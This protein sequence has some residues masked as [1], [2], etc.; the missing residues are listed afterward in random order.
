MKKI[1]IPGGSGFLG[2]KLAEYFKNKGF[3][4]VILSRSKRSSEGNIQFQEW[5][6]KNQGN[7]SSS[8]E[9]AEAV[10]NLAGRSVDCRYNQRNKDLILHSRLDATK[11]VGEAIRQC[12][13][14][15]K[16]WINAGSATIYKHSLEN[17]NDEQKGIVGSGFSVEVCKAWEKTFHNEVTPNT[18]KLFLRISIVLGKNGGAFIP[19]KQ[20]VKLGLGG[21]Q[22]SGQQ[23]ISW[24]HVEDFARSIEWLMKNKDKEGIYNIVSP[25]AE[26]NTIFMQKLRKRLEMPFGIPMPS[27]LLEFGAILIR[28]ETELI[29]KS[30]YVL[31]K[32]LE[33]EGFEFL[34]PNLGKAFGE[35]VR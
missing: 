33:D 11:A 8:L 3:L 7:W 2:M 27:F 12:K 21:K 1:V 5:D 23:M 22:G 14:P 19:I 32:R 13:T 16:V 20:L 24:I 35:L 34:Y 18:R 28:T 9:R 29:L 25:K 10:I 30:R 6:G 31:P 15:P 26:Q 4:V 17:G